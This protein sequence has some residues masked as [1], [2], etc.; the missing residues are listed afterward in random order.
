MSLNKPSKEALVDLINAKNGT[1]YT[2][3]TMGNDPPTVYTAGGDTHNTSVS[4]WHVRFP[5]DPYTVYYRRQPLGQQYGSGAGI[6]EAATPQALLDALNEEQGT[7]L[8]LDDLGPFAIPA[9][10][11]VV[12][13]TAAASS[14]G[15]IGSV[16][17]E[18][19]D[20]TPPQ[21]QPQSVP[22]SDPPVEE[23]TPPADEPVAD[24]ADEP[25]E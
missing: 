12:N 23:E 25:A 19:D 9:G 13:L 5:E 3:A 18:V 10:G 22:A 20:G 2:A 11:G 7:A 21:V 14:L 24:P 1:G 8:A 4:I 16:S 6:Y 17:V 15:Y